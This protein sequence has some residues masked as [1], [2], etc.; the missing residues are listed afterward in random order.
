MLNTSDVKSLSKGGTT[1][2]LEEISNSIDNKLSIDNLTGSNGIAIDK[3]STGEIVEVKVAAP[4]SLTSPSSGPVIS[5]T[6]NNTP[7]PA[8]SIDVTN[9][10]GPPTS[11]GLAVNSGTNYVK[12]GGREIGVGSDSSSKE[13]RITDTDVLCMNNANG[14][15]D[16]FLRQG[17]VKTLF[18]NQQSIYGSG[19]IDLYRHNIQIKINKAGSQ[20]A[21]ISTILISSSNTPI[22]S[23][24]D[25]FNTFNELGYAYPCMG[26]APDSNGVYQSVINVEPR[27]SGGISFAAN[28]P[29]FRWND[30]SL[31]ITVEDTVTTV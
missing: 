2:S 20:V 21:W 5:I 14:G 23:I 19:N 27:S 17:N 26:Y 28:G 30:T 18:G 16:Y 4:L 12:I 8:I 31:N 29:S 1:V 11:S 10:Y 13:V 3:A 25:F 24:S 7:T 22:D 15:L 6:S 9:Q